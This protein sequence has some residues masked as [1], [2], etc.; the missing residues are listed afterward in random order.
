MKKNRNRYFVIDT[1]EGAYA[2]HSEDRTEIRD[3]RVIGRK[4]GYGE[5]SMTYRQACELIQEL[6]E[7]AKLPDGQVNLTVRY[8]G[9]EHVWYPV[10]QQS[11][12][13]S[14]VPTGYVEFD[15]GRFPSLEA[16]EAAFAE[17]ELA[18]LKTCENSYCYSHNRFIS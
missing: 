18:E 5:W 10:Y 11:L 4:T 9:P 15:F 3:G 6:E 12:Y 14:S 16:A 7:Q 8:N 13:S 1:F 2:L 17:W